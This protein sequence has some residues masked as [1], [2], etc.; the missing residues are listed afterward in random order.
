MIEYRV[1]SAGSEQILLSGW[2]DHGNES[3]G[4]FKTEYQVN[5]FELLKEN[6]H[7]HAFLTSM[8]VGGEWSPSG[9][10]KQKKQIFHREIKRR[11]NQGHVFYGVHNSS[12]CLLSITIRNVFKN[13]LFHLLLFLLL[14]DRYLIS[15]KGD[16]LQA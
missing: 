9:R 14:R 1:D 13:Q 16:Q 5:D 10:R 6:I 3:S 15:R 11:I 8:L 12:S 7:L 4:T 2:Y